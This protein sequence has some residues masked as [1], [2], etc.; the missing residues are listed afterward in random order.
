MMDNDTAGL[1]RLVGLLG[2]V[3]SLSVWG[4]AKLS[5][6]RQGLVALGAAAALLVAVIYF[7]G[8]LAAAVS[9]AHPFL[10]RFP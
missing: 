4:L 8:V 6:R 7:L 2:W 3:L 1:V 10:P 9:G 5:R